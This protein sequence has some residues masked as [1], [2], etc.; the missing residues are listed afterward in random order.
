MGEEV[1][2]QP[3]SVPMKKILI[4]ENNDDMQK[5][6][7]LV[8]SRFGYE[9]VL[10]RTP[11]DVDEALGRDVFDFAVLSKSAYEKNFDKGLRTVVDAVGGS[12]VVVICNDS[13]SETARIADAQGVRACLTTPFELVFVTDILDEQNSVSVAAAEASV[14]ADG[15]DGGMNHDD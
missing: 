3:K 5:Y 14:P 13:F 9:A 4:V 1:H 7:K 2:N 12:N 6:L 11:A 15:F 8:A 10:V